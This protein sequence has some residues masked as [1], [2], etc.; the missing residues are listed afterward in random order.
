MDHMY[1]KNTRTLV[2]AYNPTGP[3]TI[4]IKEIQLWHRPE[5]CELRRKFTVR[6]Y[7]WLGLYAGTALW[8]NLC[9]VFA[10][11]TPTVWC[12]HTHENRIRRSG[13]ESQHW[14]P[15]V[16]IPYRMRCAL[17]S[18][19]IAVGASSSMPT[20]CSGCQRC[21]SDSVMEHQ[22]TRTTLDAYHV[23]GAPSILWSVV[24]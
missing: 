1:V 16:I 10:Y 23:I 19:A 6:A 12:V 15:S 18:V 9:Y 8:I 17:L 24:T 2:A 21:S 5:V 14:F 11:D 22:P 13:L 7:A 4:R 20:T 3:R